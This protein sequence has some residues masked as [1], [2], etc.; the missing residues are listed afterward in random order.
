MASSRDS[1]SAPTCH[2]RDAPPPPAAARRRLLPQPPPLLGGQ[3]GRP[4]HQ[5]PPQVPATHPACP[6]TPRTG[7]EWPGVPALAGPGPLHSCPQRAPQAH[8]ERKEMAV[9][10]PGPR[11]LG[12]P[13]HGPRPGDFEVALSRQT[14]CASV[15]RSPRRTDRERVSAKSEVC[16]YCAHRGATGGEPSTWPPASPLSVCGAGADGPQG[17]SWWLRSV[18]HTREMLPPRGAQKERQAH[19]QDRWS[20]GRAHTDWFSL[21]VWL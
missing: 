8:R 3:E 16:N 6:G 13:L 11:G 19:T 10:P 17:E 15:T 20:Q 9:L 14:S 18:A 1:C 12:S 4:P 7:T 5:H 2:R 21:H